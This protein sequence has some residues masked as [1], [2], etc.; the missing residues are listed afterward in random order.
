DYLNKFCSAYLDDILI[1]NNNPF[2]YTKHRLWDVKLYINLKK[3]K[4]L[5][6]EVKYLKLIITTKGIRIDPKKVYIV[7]K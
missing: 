1:Y 4:F 6:I 2:K 3:Y 5:V 7:T